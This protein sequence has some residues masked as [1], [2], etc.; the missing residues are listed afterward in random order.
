Q[1]EDFS[2]LEVELDRIQE[3]EKPGGLERQRLVSLEEEGFAS[4]HLKAEGRRDQTGPGRQPRDR[5]FEAQ[6][7]GLEGFFI[8]AS[9]NLLFDAEE[10]LSQ[11]LG[12]RQGIRHGRLL[13]RGEHPYGISQSRG[14]GGGIEG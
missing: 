9:R 7:E 13:P 12:E 4:R 10:S 2:G 8:A 3:L 11:A 14:A 6:I 5:A 1:L